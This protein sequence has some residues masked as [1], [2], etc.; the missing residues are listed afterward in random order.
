MVAV[1]TAKIDGIF[2]ALGVLFGIFSF[3]ET[4][5]N[6]NDF[7]Y[8]SYM[9][10]FTLMDWLHLPT[11]VVVVLVVLMALFMFWGA[12]KLEVI[13]GGADQSKAPKMRYIGAGALVVVA[14][15]VLLIGQP[16]ASDK[17]NALSAEKNPQLVEERAYQIHPGELLSLIH[18]DDIKLF[19]F[20]IRSESD[21]N[22][23][24]IKHAVDHAVCFQLQR[25]VNGR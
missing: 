1:A 18:N 5:E 6:F 22:L 13:F 15:V 17:W 12:E 9:G 2:F 25:Q 23:F 10:R 19:M 21:Y 20:D 4:V 14:L 3:G 16:T 24:H 7:F 11:G 8:S